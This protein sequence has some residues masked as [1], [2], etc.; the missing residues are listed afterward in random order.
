[1]IWLTHLRFSDT[2][3]KEL[4]ALERAQAR[5][6]IRSLVRRVQS[7]DPLAHWATPVPAP[8]PGLWRFS[9][10]SHDLLFHWHPAAGTLV[11]LTLCP[12]HA[13]DR[14]PTPQARP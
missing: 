14:L 1:M 4:T 10:S 5:A 3:L 12:T 7:M 9:F 6:L 11:V 13:S 2:A 8:L